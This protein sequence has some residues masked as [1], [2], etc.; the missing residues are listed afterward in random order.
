VIEPG[1]EAWVESDEPA[2]LIQFEYEG[3]TATRSGCA[4]DTGTSRC[5]R[6]R[7]PIRPSAARSSWWR[8]SSC[9]IPSSSGSGRNCLSIAFTGST[10]KKN[11]AAG[12]EMNW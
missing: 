10:T 4:P 7:A 1:Y 3:D 2:V 8:R 5:R 11:T 12:I 9:D 6:Y